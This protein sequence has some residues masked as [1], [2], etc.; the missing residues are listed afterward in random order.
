MVVWNEE[1]RL[2]GLLGLSSTASQFQPPS[3]SCSLRRRF[4]SASFGLLKYA[5]RPRILPLMQGSVSPCRKGRL[6]SG[7]NTSR[8]STRSIILRACL[9]AGSRPRAFKTT[10]LLKVVSRPRSSFAPPQLPAV[11]CRARSLAPQPSV[12]TRDR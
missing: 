11:D 5:P 10:R 8:L 12:A 4:A 2:L 7:L 6:L 3:S 9:L 1:R